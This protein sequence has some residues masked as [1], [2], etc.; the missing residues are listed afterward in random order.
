MTNRALGSTGRV[1][2][3]AAEVTAG[4][5]GGDTTTSAAS[6][7]AGALPRSGPIPPAAG[8]RGHRMVV[9]MTPVRAWRLGDQNLARVGPFSLGGHGAAVP[10]PAH[11]P[12]W[13]PFAASAIFT[14]ARIY[15]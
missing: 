7:A 9:A 8:A 11:G 1:S 6:L 4:R 14:A 5:T 2:P 12:S 10:V 3:A 15:E 13:A